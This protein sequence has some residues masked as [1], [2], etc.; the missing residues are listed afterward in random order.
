MPTVLL[1]LLILLSGVCFAADDKAEYS[2][3]WGKNGEKWNPSG[4]L[5]D[6][7]Y[8]GYRMGEV[9]IPSPAVKCSVKDFGAKGDGSTDD[10]KAFQ[11]ALKKTTGGAILIPA[12]KYVI[13]DFLEIDKSNLVLRGEGPGKT[14]LFFP[15]YL[16]DIKP[17]WGA[18]TSGQKT[19]NYSWGGGYIV[20][21]GSNGGKAL[22]KIAEPAKRGEHVIVLEKACTLKKG[23]FIEIR[24]KDNPDNAMMKHLYCGQPGDMAKIPGSTRTSFVSRITAVE[25]APAVRS[26]AGTEAGATTAGRDAGATPRTKVTLERALRSDVDPAW[27]AE[28]FEFAPRVVDSGVEELTFEFPP[29]LYKGHFTELGHNPALISGA[30]HCWIRNVRVL[31]GESGPYLGGWFCTV[32][33]ITLDSTCT[34]DKTGCVGHHGITL[35]GT[36]NLAEDFTFTCKYIHDL[37]VEHSAGN[38][39]HRG[40]GVDMCFDHH[41]RAP[42]ANLFTN[43]DIGE[44]KRM[45]MCGGGA[46]LGKHSGAWETFWNLRAKQP[47]KLWSPDFG[48]DMMNFVGVESRE[49]PVLKPEGRWW[50][51]ISPARLQPQDLYEAQLMKRTKK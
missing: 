41:K 9:P 8:A 18:T 29:Q 2:E 35:Y 26:T 39:F 11:D 6:F 22:G 37:T 51:P 42:H 24:Q 47:Q 31:N 25:V 49:Q 32:S 19:S 38:V 14:A 50:E 44:G 36:D 5:P 20:I 40:K 4:R 10:T 3:L 46:A 34:P 23:D 17:N 13:T 48:P 30:S 33:G 45:Y 28:G 43:I 1:A 21:K 12:G 27:H 15:K 7:S 16:N